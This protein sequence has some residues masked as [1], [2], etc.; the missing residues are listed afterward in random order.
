MQQDTARE[1]AEHL[2]MIYEAAKRQK[3]EEERQAAQAKAEAEAEA[4]RQRIEREK[5]EQKARR[6]Q[7][8]DKFKRWASR[9]VSDED[10]IM[11]PSGENTGK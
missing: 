9:F 3:E 8:W 7:K 1:A 10:N 5:A 2:Y 6:K 11:P 4:E